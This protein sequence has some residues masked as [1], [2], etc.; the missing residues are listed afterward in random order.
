[1]TNTVLPMARPSRVQVPGLV[2]R[3]VIAVVDAGRE[4]DRQ[5]A[6]L[7]I[8]AGIG[9][10]VEELALG[11]VVLAVQ[12]QLQVVRVHPL[13]QGIDAIAEDA[14]ADQEHFVRSGHAVLAGARPSPGAR[15]APIMSM[16]IMRDDLRERH[17]RRRHELP[18]APQAL[19]FAAV[20]DEDDRPL[21][22][23]RHHL[24]RDG[25]VG[26]AAGGVVVRG[27]VDAVAVH[28]RACPRRRRD[29]TG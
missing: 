21:R 14:R 18:R 1:M 20:P 29:A 9:A 15:L 11:R 3:Q 28:R 10:R 4:P 16:L 2:G 5:H 19:L 23:R 26:R 7:E 17:R 22:P 13:E 24:L 12:R 25:D 6:A 27:V 8:R